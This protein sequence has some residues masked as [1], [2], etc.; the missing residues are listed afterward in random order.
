MWCESL[1]IFLTNTSTDS[2][3]TNICKVD[4]QLISKLADNRSYI[5]ILW[6][7]NRS[8]GYR[9]GDLTGYLLGVCFAS[10]AHSANDEDAKQVVAL[11]AILGTISLLV[12]IGV[13][14]GGAA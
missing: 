11:S 2:G 4:A 10:V 6:L 3:S 14:M 12:L 1:Q 5:S 9:R 13:K 8:S 7:R